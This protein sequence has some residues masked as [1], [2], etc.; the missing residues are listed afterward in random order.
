MA[1]FRPLE[2][3]RFQQVFLRVRKLESGMIENLDAVVVIRIVGGRNHHS[4]RKRTRARHVR[5]P[6]C[7]DQTREPRPHSALRKPAR[8]VFRDPWTRLARVHSDHD[9][10][11]QMMRPDP[12]CKRYTNREGSGPIERILVRLPPDSIGPK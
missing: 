8:H 1:R 2:D 9:F 7:R 12:L 5:Q 4:R 6:R 10:G 3:M 11:I